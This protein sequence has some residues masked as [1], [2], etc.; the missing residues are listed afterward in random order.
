MSN[1]AFEGPKWSSSTITW[2]FAAAGGTF[3]GAITGAYQSIV[4]QALARWT[5]VAGV[6]FRQVT[7][8]AASDVRI[9]W[10]Q[11][12]GNQV[13]ETDYSYVGNNFVAGLTVRL[14][15]PAAKPIASAPGSYYLGTATTLYEVALH[16][17]GHA[18]GLAHSTDTSAVMYP[19]VGPGNSDLDGS[20][21]Q[22]IQAIY[23]AAASSTPQTTQSLTI[24]Q[25]TPTPTA[26]PTPTS[27][28][29]PPPA[30]TLSGNAVAV[31]RFFDANNGTQFLTASLAERNTIITSRPD[32]SYEGLGMGALSSPVGDANAVPVYR[33]FD[34]A[35]G[36]HFFTTSQTEN[37]Q[38]FASRPDLVSEQVT[39]YEHATQQAGDVPV[40]RFF[41]SSTGTHFYTSSPSETATLQASRADMTLEGVAFYAPSATASNA[42]FEVANGA[43]ALDP[44]TISINDSTVLIYRFDAAG[45]QQLLTADAAERNAVLTAQPS[46]A[47]QGAVM[48]AISPDAGDPQAAPVFRFFNAATGDHFLT[49]DSAEAA[50][51]AAT[52][53]DLMQEQPA[54]YEHLTQQSGDVAVYRFF[55]TTSGTH[56][57]TTDGAE[58]ASILATRPD[59]AQEGIAFY[60]PSITTAPAMA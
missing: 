23:G 18:L 21:I 34:T 51:L 16:E 8:S 35:N 6:T 15:D 3:T 32:L 47:Y 56:F 59:M 44:A 31:Y 43:T 2:S 53:P 58:R 7:D 54:F 9:G 48:G 40:Y 1:Y 19:S 26:T 10:G 38:I 25:T 5:Q 12:S 11:F 39:F 45:G 29:A 57:Y 20:D 28:Q 22:G 46:F 4:E 52:R 27:T 13:G 37:A 49:A 55:D 30:I 36:S 41:D 24:V 60:A 50:Q 42:Q 33:F 17:I 14:E